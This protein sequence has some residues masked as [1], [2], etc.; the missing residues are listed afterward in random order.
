M[1]GAAAGVGRTR[2]RG[3]EA[4]QNLQRAAAEGEAARARAEIRVGR[5][6]ERAA[7]DGRT[8]GIGVGGSEDGRSRSD[9]REAPAS[10]NDTAESESVGAVDG[11][12]A[13]VDHI[14]GERAA[15]AAVAEL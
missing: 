13:V 1:E 6:R 2:A 4:R 7:V 3:A 15:R 14:A 11:E 5:N 8:A 12:D 10:G 9:L